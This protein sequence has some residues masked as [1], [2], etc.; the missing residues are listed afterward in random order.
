M[1]EVFEVSQFFPGISAERIYYAWMDSKSHSAFTGSSAQID[2]R[3]G[4]LFTAWDGYISGQ[5][6]E[7]QPFRRIVQNWR[8]TE[9][10]DDSPDSR[11]EIIIV[12]VA[13][14]T[15]V[16][17]RHS[18][19]PSGQGENYRQGWEEFYFKPMREYFQI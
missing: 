17:L 5:T 14:G 15:K 13:G 16:E 3:V 4:G 6:L 19:I 9:F 7:M 12:E 10:P 2:N 1:S 11:L 8:T 18:N